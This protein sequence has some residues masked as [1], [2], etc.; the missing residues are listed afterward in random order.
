MKK[1]ALIGSL[2]IGLVAVFSIFVASNFGEK[3]DIY[4]SGE[5]VVPHSLSNRINNF[6]VLYIVIYDENSPMP[7]PYGAMKLRLEEPVQAG[8]GVPFFV[9]KERIQT[10]RENQPP[11]QAM[12][13]K[14]RFDRDGNA[15][16]DQP[17]DLTGE[18]LG[19][20]YGTT[21]LTIAID[22]YISGH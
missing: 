12:R 8:V 1:I 3:S 22:K 17:G 11:P 19:V 6:K 20:A 5:V 15:G 21:G 10:M 7:M 16:R 18:Q 9:T 4:V 2:L 14:A 13:V